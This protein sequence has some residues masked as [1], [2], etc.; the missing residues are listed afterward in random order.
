MAKPNDDTAELMA[1]AYAM[2][3]AGSASFG[4]K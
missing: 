1:T 3:V 2:L 4:D